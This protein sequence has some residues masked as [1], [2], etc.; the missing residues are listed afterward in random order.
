MKPYRDRTPTRLRGYDYTTPGFYFITICTFQREYL[1]GE[2]INSAMNLNSA[3]K[4]VQSVWENLP[5]RYSHV[6]AGE[7]IVMPN[8]FHGVIEIT[9][10]NMD[11]EKDKKYGLSEIVRGFKAWSSRR[12]NLVQ[13]TAG[14]PVW[15]RSFYDRIIRDDFQLENAMMYIKMNPQRWEEDEENHLYV[16]R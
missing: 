1:F 8:H 4:I 10:V 14:V 3:G 9:S 6:H 5:Q 15:Q 16:K 7:F 11:I 13:N 12:I 2:I